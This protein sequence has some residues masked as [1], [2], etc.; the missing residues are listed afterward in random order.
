MPPIE[1]FL[2]EEAGHA[3]ENWPNA[4]VIR[5]IPS[6][7][8][9]LCRAPLGNRIDPG[10]FGGHRDAV[11]KWR[12]M[13]YAALEAGLDRGE[14]DAA[15]DSGR[16]MDDACDPGVEMEP[17]TQGWQ[18]PWLCRIVPLPKEGREGGHYFVEY[19]A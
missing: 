6:T 10:V 4:A 9:I 3:H 2:S 7:Q 14:G 18:A 16:V 19:L 8:V 1:T 13:Y 17:N 11:R 12:E 5:G 15:V